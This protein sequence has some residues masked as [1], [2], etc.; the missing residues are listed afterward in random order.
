MLS[1][2]VSDGHGTDLVCSILYDINSGW[3]LPKTIVGDRHRQQHHNIKKY[4]MYIPSDILLTLICKEIQ[5]EI[6][7][8]DNTGTTLTQIQQ[9]FNVQ[10]TAIKQ[11]LQQLSYPGKVKAV[12][13][14]SNYLTQNTPQPLPNENLNNFLKRRAQRDAV[15]ACYWKN[16]YINHA[17]KEKDNKDK[18]S[19]YLYL[20][21]QK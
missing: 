5:E 12:E 14:L 1:S 2:K 18:D 11:D 7:H 4:V 15:N 16:G 10:K 19:H 13:K 21:D 20:I 17:N 8:P 3:L 6:V 9:M